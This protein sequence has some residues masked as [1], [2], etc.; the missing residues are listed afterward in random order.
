VRHDAAAEFEVCSAPDQPVTRET[1]TR[2]AAVAYLAK[3]FAREILREAVVRAS[4]ERAANDI[5]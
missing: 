1:A 2:N 5:A 3:P 4:F